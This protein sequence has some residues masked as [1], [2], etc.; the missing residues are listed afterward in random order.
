MTPPDP[1]DFEHTGVRRTDSI[2]SSSSQEEKGPLQT[3]IQQTLTD[4]KKGIKRS[5]SSPRKKKTEG[6]VVKRFH[7]VKQFSPNP[8]AKAKIHYDKG[9]KLSRFA[10]KTGRIKKRHRYRLETKALQ[11]I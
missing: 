9:K 1:K 7:S 2:S 8:P 10:S 11:K 3:S 4:R 5:I 6:L